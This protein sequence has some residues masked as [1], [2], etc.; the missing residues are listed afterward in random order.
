MGHWQLDQLSN[1]PKWKSELVV[2]LVAPFGRRY[3][4]N[5]QEF[6]GMDVLFRAIDYL[7]P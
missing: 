3:A 6:L 7:I 1:I 4:N 5:I 2:D